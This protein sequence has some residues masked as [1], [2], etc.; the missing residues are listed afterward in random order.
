MYPAAITWKANSD[1]DESE[2]NP[3]SNP[4]VDELFKSGIMFDDIE[5]LER[6]GD[7]V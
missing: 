7:V 2:D 1:S 5:K 6:D 3:G 4:G